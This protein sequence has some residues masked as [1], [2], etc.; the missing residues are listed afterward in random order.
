MPGQVNEVEPHPFDEALPSR[1][2]AGKRGL[3]VLADRGALRAFTVILE[4]AS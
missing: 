4:L 3:T 2:G 1:G